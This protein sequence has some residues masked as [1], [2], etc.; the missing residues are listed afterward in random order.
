MKT[1][2]ALSALILMSACTSQPMAN[3]D[4]SLVDTILTTPEY[5][6]SV[7]QLEVRTDETPVVTPP[8]TPPP[9]DL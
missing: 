7:E 3:D 4:G 5:D 1:L 2:L 6:S 8:T 9:V